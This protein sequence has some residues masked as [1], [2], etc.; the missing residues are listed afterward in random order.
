MASSLRI[1]LSNLVSVAIQ[2]SIEWRALLKEIELEVLDSSGVGSHWRIFSLDHY[3][4]ST[5]CV[6][7]L[8]RI[9]FDSWFLRESCF[10]NLDHHRGFD[11]V[12]TYL[13]HDEGIG[14]EGL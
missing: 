2:S 8:S 6:H 10:N 5:P 14:Q 11:I 9:S 7:L 3:I 4:F 13:C 1:P 12:A